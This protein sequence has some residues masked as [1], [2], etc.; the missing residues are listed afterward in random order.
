MSKPTTDVTPDAGNVAKAEHIVARAIEAIGGAAYL[1]TRTQTSRGRFTTFVESKSTLPLTFDDTV[2]YPDKQRTEFRGGGT[3][4]IQ[5]NTGSTGWL[6][7]AATRTLKDL[8]QTQI[9]DFKIALRA[10][11]DTLLR[12]EW[13]KAGENKVVLSYVGRREASL[14]RRNEV[15]RLTYKDNFAVDFAFD[16]QTFLPAKISYPRLTDK[17]PDPSKTSDTSA[18]IKVEVTEEDRFALFTN[19]GGVLVPFVIDHFRDG[20]QTSRVNYE[21]VE[22]NLPVADL[23]FARPADVKEI[24][25]K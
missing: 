5:V 4:I 21:S 7:D 16:G 6:F 15:V 13:R 9:E 25:F 18:M 19:A 8:T 10:N 17:A 20:K 2:V 1:Q 23:I 24:K 14:G 22:F 3:R 12:G 11:L